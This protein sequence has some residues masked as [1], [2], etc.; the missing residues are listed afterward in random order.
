MSNARPFLL[1]DQGGVGGHNQGFRL[2]RHFTESIVT[3][4]S[5]EEPPFI[6][7]TILL[8]KGTHIP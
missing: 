6:P 4:I 7:P 5:S 2:S 8:S 3:S 1:G